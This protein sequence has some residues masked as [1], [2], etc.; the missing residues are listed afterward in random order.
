M[1]GAAAG[2]T[3]G[4]SIDV[5]VMASERLLALAHTDVPQLE[6]QRKQVSH[7]LTLC[8][9]PITFSPFTLPSKH[10]PHPPTT[11]LTLPSHPSLSH[12]RPQTLAVASQAPDTNRLLLSGAMEI[13][14]TSPVCPRKVDSSCPVSMF[15][16]A[17]KE[18]RGEG[19]IGRCCKGT[20]PV[21]ADLLAPPTGPPKTDLTN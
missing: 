6:G 1:L 9:P 5:L 12:L 19:S 8:H 14:I 13:L 21:S 4:N 3:H 7:N 11:P 18:T 15:H 16:N 2:G 10:T 20:T 17:L